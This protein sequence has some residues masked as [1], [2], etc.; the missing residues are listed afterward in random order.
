MCMPAAITGETD[1]EQA[2]LSHGTSYEWGLSGRVLVTR[3][4][5]AAGSSFTR[6]AV[7]CP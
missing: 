3:D 7:L 1:G 6:V 5:G 2:F 4:R